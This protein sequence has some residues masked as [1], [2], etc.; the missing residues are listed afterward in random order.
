MLRQKCWRKIFLLSIN[1]QTARLS[2]RKEWNW[3]HDVGS[4]FLA[5]VST[6][7]LVQSVRRYTRQNCTDE[8]SRVFMTCI[9][10]WFVAEDVQKAKVRCMIL[11]QVNILT[12]AILLFVICNFFFKKK[13]GVIEQMHVAWTAWFS[14][15]VRLQNN[16]SRWIVYWFCIKRCFMKRIFRVYVGFA[17]IRNTN[18]ELSYPR[19]VKIVWHVWRAAVHQPDFL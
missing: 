8:S 15:S 16:G 9:C 10:V 7:S 12:R 4:Q 14:Q 6:W 19:F 18:V 11:K 3:N 5:S 2:C 1:H 13:V 17:C